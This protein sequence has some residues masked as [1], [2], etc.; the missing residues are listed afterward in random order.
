ML[1]Q[2]MN[3]CR[4]VRKEVVTQPSDKETNLC[5]LQPNINPRCIKLLLSTH[6][7]SDRISRT[8]LREH[9]STLGNMKDL[10]FLC[11]WISWYKILQMKTNS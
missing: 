11:D 10:M 7:F 9:S 6:K 4:V 3:L 1:S 2:G 5:L 8:I